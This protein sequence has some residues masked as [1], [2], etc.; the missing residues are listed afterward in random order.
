MRHRQPH[1]VHVPEGIRQFLDPLVG[2]PGLHRQPGQ[3]VLL[4]TEEAPGRLPARARPAHQG[5]GLAS[6]QLHE[7][8]QLPDFRVGRRQTLHVGHQRADA[9]VVGGSVHKDDAAG[10]GEQALRVDVRLRVG[11]VHRVDERVQRVQLL[12]GQSVSGLLRAVGDLHLGRPVETVG[13][14]HGGV[15]LERLLRVPHRTFPVLHHHPTVGDRDAPMPDAVGGELPGDQPVHLDDLDGLGEPLVGPGLVVVLVPVGHPAA[16]ELQ[17]GLLVHRVLGQPLDRFL[18][19]I[20]LVRVGV[21]QHVVQIGVVAVAAPRH[22][23]DVVLAGLLT[24]IQPVDGLPDGS[25][26]HGR[27]ILMDHR[28]RISGGHL[29]H[30][31][32]AGLAFQVLPAEA[33]DSGSADVSLQEEVDPLDDGVGVLHLGGDEDL[34]LLGP[35]AVLRSVPLEAHDGPR[36]EGGLDLT[37]HV[38]LD[39]GERERDGDVVPELRQTALP[40]PSIGVVPTLELGEQPLVVVHGVPPAR[41]HQFYLARL[42][43]THELPRS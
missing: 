19:E 25:V 39:H 9:G 41:V 5:L 40:D 27:V 42:G 33:G 22:V 21:V 3:G 16:T 18:V 4:P 11:D 15:G 24:K 38:A 8:E 7:L 10:A 26:E 34:V 37:G 13:V 20:R 35:R 30:P 29:L 43:H 32:N 36:A 23:L 2:Q 6:P 17:S 12:V 1:P 28:D 14:R 31:A